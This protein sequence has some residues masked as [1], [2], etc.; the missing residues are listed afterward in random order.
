MKLRKFNETILDD[1]RE[2][3][4]R[5]EEERRQRDEEAKK[6]QQELIS[7][8]QELK[9]ASEEEIMKKEE[10]DYNLEKAELLDKLGEIIF[11]SLKENDEEPKNEISALID[12]YA[13]Y[14]GKTKVLSH[15]PTQDIKRF[16]DYSMPPSAKSNSDVMPEVVNT[17]GAVGSALGS[18]M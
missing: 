6:R 16:S 3:E 17:I 15:I 11:Y 4:K 9:K 10:P 1:I 14:L 7:Q 12:K 8:H 18:G 2:E 13:K 5:K